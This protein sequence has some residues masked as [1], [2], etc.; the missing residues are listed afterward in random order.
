M[1]KFFTLFLYTVIFVVPIIIPCASIGLII[2]KRRSNR[3]IVWTVLLTVIL[4]MLSLI[5]LYFLLFDDGL[6]I[7][8][9]S[10]IILNLFSV[11][12]VSG[13]IALTV[14]IIKRIV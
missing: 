10:L 3:L 14:A 13:V 7:M 11:A 4:E 1:E 6:A 8:G 2:K 5:P 9:I 12:L